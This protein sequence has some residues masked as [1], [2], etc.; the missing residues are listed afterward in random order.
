M[1]IIV[2]LSLLVWASVDSALFIIGDQ[3]S[4]I[5]DL[6]LGEVTNLILALITLTVMNYFSTPT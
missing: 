1:L 6:L 5:F 3:L 2:A 4:W